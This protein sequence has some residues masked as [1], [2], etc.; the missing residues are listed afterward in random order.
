MS[1]T[2]RQ[3]TEV[4][5]PWFCRTCCR[6]GVCVDEADA[7]RAHLAAIRCEESRGIPGG[8][9]SE[10]FTATEHVPDLVINEAP[11]KRRSPRI[12]PPRLPFE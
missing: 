6:S 10:K 8:W 5:K 11:Q 12:Q 3:E 2:K 4:F 9:P 1:R 7:I